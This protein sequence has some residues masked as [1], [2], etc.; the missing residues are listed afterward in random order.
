MAEVWWNYGESKKTSFQGILGLR[1]LYLIEIYYGLL[2]RY[3]WGG[4]SNLEF[5][6]IFFFFN[7]IFNVEI[8]FSFINIV[9]LSVIIGWVKWKFEHFITKN[10]Y[11]STFSTEGIWRNFK[12]LI[13]NQIRSKFSP[14]LSISPFTFQRK[15]PILIKLVCNLPIIIMI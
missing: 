1:G 11:I 15:G 10:A 3:I 6:W 2:Y 13:C 9:L 12:K 8:Y 5:K 14:S 7:T 4:G